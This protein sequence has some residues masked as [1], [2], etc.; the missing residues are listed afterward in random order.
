MMGYY[1]FGNGL[2]GFTWI[3]VVVIAMWGAITW[4]IVWLV[5]KTKRPVHSYQTP[6]D[7]LKQRYARGE[8][9]ARELNERKNMLSRE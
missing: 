4:L 3:F 1:D 9:S 8:I 2:L 6:L 7:I 5:N